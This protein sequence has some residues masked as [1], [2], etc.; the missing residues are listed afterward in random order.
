[1]PNKHRV[2]TD[3]KRVRLGNSPLAPYRHFIEYCE[4]FLNWELL[5]FKMGGEFAAHLIEMRKKIYHVPGID[6][7]S[8]YLP[9]HDSW[10]DGRIMLLARNNKSKRQKYVLISWAWNDVPLIDIPKIKEIDTYSKIGKSRCSNYATFSSDKTLRRYADML[11]NTMNA[12]I[13][14][15]LNILD[16]ITGIRLGLGDKK[17]DVLHDFDS[18]DTE[19]MKKHNVIMWSETELTL[20]TCV[21][22]QIYTDIPIDGIDIFTDKFLMQCETENPNTLFED[23]PD[24]KEEE[25]TYETSTKNMLGKQDIKHPVEQEMVAPGRTI[26]GIAGTE[27]ETTGTVPIPPFAPP[28]A[29]PAPPTVRE[30]TPVDLDVAP[31]PNSSALMPPSPPFLRRFINAVRNEDI[32]PP[33]SPVPPEPLP[34]LDDFVNNY[35]SSPINLRPEDEVK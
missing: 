10:K 34:S 8:R 30:N 35:V 13:V 14:S 22:E 6:E 7:F 4:N 12:T 23:N 2:R 29:P 28:F 24:C 27:G 19:L 17:H 3:H 15:N 25:F 16:I 9:S 26:W 33:Q 11:K 18:T 31:M 20:S 1:M 5:W 32:Y 21:G